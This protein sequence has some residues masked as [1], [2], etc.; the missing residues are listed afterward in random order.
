MKWKRSKKSQHEAKQRNEDDT[1]TLNYKRLAQQ[2][3]STPE[4]KF[5]NKEDVSFK[6][7]STTNHIKNN[8]AK[9][10]EIMQMECKAQSNS[11]EKLFRP[12]QC[13]K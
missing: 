11:M 13:Y 10:E 9:V 1:D 2:Q 3:K 5:I 4:K 12:Y 7:F 6:S 8:Q